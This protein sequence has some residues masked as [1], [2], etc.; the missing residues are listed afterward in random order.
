ME[1][2]FRETRFAFVPKNNGKWHGFGSDPIGSRRNEGSGA[3]T[4]GK[5]ANG[6]NWTDLPTRTPSSYPDVLIPDSRTGSNITI[7]S[8]NIETPKQYHA[9]LVKSERRKLHRE[10]IATRNLAIKQLK[11]GD[12]GRGAPVPAGYSVDQYGR[13][14]EGGIKNPTTEQSNAQANFT[15]G[16]YY[17][18]NKELLKSSK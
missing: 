10:L 11:R 15:G 5:A 1:H 12:I 18:E 17:R 2:F 4:Y 6:Y 7:P 3:N 8:T 9:Y 13:L 16:G 14:R